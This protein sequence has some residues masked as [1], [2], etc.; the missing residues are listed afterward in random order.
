MSDN[1][2]SGFR[3]ITRGIKPGASSPVTKN[4]KKILSRILK[5]Q[6]DRIAELRARYDEKTE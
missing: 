1:F 4:S 3:K 2:S 5:D 6:S